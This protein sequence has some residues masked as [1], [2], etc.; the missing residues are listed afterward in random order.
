MAVLHSQSSSPM[1][2]AFLGTTG[3]YALNPQ[4]RPCTD[5]A[6]SVYSI[7]YKTGVMVADG[8]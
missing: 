5:E 8:A 7:L 6:K 1:D 4:L 2:L 3:I